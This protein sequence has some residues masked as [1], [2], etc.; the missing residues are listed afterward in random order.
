M[1]KLSLI[2]AISIFNISLAE[3]TTYYVRPKGGTRAQCTG[4]TDADYPG[5][6][7]GKPCGFK[8]PM[9]ALGIQSSRDLNSIMKSGDT[10]FIHSGSYKIGYD[11]SLEPYYCGVSSAFDCR[12]RPIP[13][14]T[15]TAHTKILGETYNAGCTHPP[16]L[17]GTEKVNTVLDL[18]GSSYTDV[19]CLE[20]TDHSNCRQGGPAFNRCNDGNFPK[21]PWG[22]VGIIAFAAHN[23]H[24]TDINIHGMAAYGLWTGQ[25]KDWIMNRVKIN[26]QGQAGW[27]GEYDQGNSSNSG[28]IH[29][30]NSQIMW[31]GCAETYP[32]KTSPVVGSCCSQGQGCYNDG[33]GMADSGGNYIIEDSNVS[34]NAEDGIDL[35]HVTLNP[36]T[37]IV[38][39]RTRV[40]GNAGNGVKTGATNVRLENN[41]LISG[42][43][44]LEKAG[45]TAAGWTYNDNTCRGGGEP[46][47]I[48]I[49]TNSQHKLYNNT[50]IQTVSGNNLSLYSKVQGILCNGTESVTWSNNIA[51]GGNYLQYNDV[52]N[53][54]GW[55][56][57]HLKNDHNLIYNVSSGCPSGNG[58]LCGN[59]LLMNASSTSYFPKMDV[60]LKAA[61][62]AITKAN[63]ALQFTD[64]SNDYFHALRGKVWDIG[65]A[66]YGI[67]QP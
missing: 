43:N 55:N 42:C 48:D 49:A 11:A 38:I 53:C 66:E 59:P 62:P 67:V 65:S 1:F 12:P 61:S 3:A 27:H 47:G 8:N 22:S 28:T 29:L 40:E 19:S 36:P 7:T 9:W 25:L 46:V 64:S 34:F 52:A 18:R 33:I 20:I 35:L 10:L 24:L 4:T 37:S 63:A 5:S 2:F 54:S 44:Y 30:K 32:G 56:L 39:R 57:T 31:N 23:V 13:A 26:G 14:G 60:Q 21:G 45:Y 51:M 41:I 6:G 58:N 50:I 17:W 15:S 16:Q